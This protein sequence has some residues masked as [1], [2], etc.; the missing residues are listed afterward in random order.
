MSVALSLR[1][2]Q[3]LRP[4]GFRERIKNV[5]FVFYFLFNDKTLTFKNIHVASANKNDF[6]DDSGS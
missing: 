2:F 5:M 1:F 4:P 3:V 6:G